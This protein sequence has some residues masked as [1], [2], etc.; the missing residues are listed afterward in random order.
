MAFRLPGRGQAKVLRPAA[1]ASAYLLCAAALL[2]SP[3]AA[4]Q[5]GFKQLPE[6]DR[7]IVTKPPSPEQL[8]RAESEATQRRRMIEEARQAKAPP[9]LFPP[10]APRPAPYAG[11]FW[12]H[13]VAYAEPSYVCYGR[14]YFEQINAERYGWDLGPIHP[15][16]SLGKFYW[17]V[18]T[19]PY[20]LATDPCRCY[21]C[22]NH[23]YCLPGSPVPLMIY[24]PELSATGALA[25]AAAIGL[26]FL[27]FP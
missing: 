18:L 10:A 6:A 11:R 12:A 24:P 20:H 27:A 14:L 7:T 15:L 17:D 3:R 13:T 8:F 1:L 16:V 4:A 5:V 9:P 21:E 26:L 19:F 25:E 23:G 2:R 22:S